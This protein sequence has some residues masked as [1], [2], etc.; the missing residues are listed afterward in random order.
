MNTLIVWVH[1]FADF[2]L[3]SRKMAENKSSSNSWLTKHILVYSLCLVPFG[4][5]YALVNG[6]AHW[7]TDWVSS[8]FTSK[9]YKKANWY[10]FFGVVG[11][12]QGM[13]LT[14]LLNTKEL[15]WW[16]Q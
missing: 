7:M 10:M 2:F 9:Y 8:R 12:D 16:A 4:W 11:I 14:V 13:H 6:I 3:Q 15:M 5:K 1:I